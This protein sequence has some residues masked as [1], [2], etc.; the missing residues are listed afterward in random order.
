MGLLAIRFELRLRFEGNRQLNSTQSDSIVDELL[1][2]GIEF[3]ARI[4][5]ISVSRLPSSVRLRQQRSESAAAASAAAAASPRQETSSYR[6]HL[7]S[8]LLYVL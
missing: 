8:S 5:E 1:T 6:E 2:S 3:R 4:Y 7:F